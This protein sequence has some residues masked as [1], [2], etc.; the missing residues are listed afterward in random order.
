MGFASPNR[1]EANLVR[2]DYKKGDEAAPA[3]TTTN[4]NVT[5]DHCCL[6]TGLNPI[7]SISPQVSNDGF[8]S[9]EAAWLSRSSKS[10]F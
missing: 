2:C 7:R 4:T 1:D 8:D 10:S 9:V 5:I 3:V 6:L